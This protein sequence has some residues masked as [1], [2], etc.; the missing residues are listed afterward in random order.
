MNI[1]GLLLTK[2]PDGATAYL[3]MNDR[4]IILTT[5]GMLE[6]AHELLRDAIGQAVTPR[7]EGEVPDHANQMAGSRRDP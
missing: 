5:T 3:T 7:G 2:S 6:L 4:H 1:P